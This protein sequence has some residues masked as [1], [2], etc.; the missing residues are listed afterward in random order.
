MMRP[1]KN[2]FR[3][4]NSRQDHTNTCL[5]QLA[6][7]CEALYQCVSES[8]GPS[9]A[10]KVLVEPGR[11]IVVTNC[12]HTILSR[13]RTSNPL[14]NFVLRC[15]DN[16]TTCVGDGTTAFTIILCRTLRN[17]VAHLQSNHWRTN[18]YRIQLR[19]LV[20]AFQY[21]R[22]NFEE[23]VVKPIY[24]LQLQLLP[25]H[26]PIKVSETPQ[27]DFKHG[28]TTVVDESI[29]A[30][31][32]E[33]KLIIAN[34]CVA[35]FGLDTATYLTTILEL[36]IFR[37]GMQQLDFSA[38]LP[39]NVIRNCLLQHILSAT[40]D[41]QKMAEV[42]I[43]HAPGISLSSS[44]IVSKDTL[45]LSCDF[46]Y[47]TRLLFQTVSAIQ[48][49]IFALFDGSLE[50]T[51]LDDDS[52]NNSS[53]EG[54]QEVDTTEY[55]A[56]SAD[57]TTEMPN[58][59]SDRNKYQVE[60]DSAKTYGDFLQQESR[61]TAAL[62]AFC[63]R[64]KVN[65]LF[66]K[67]NISTGIAQACARNGIALVA[68]VPPL[69]MWQL[70]QRSG[71]AT[72]ELSD[73]VAV[74]SSLRQVIGYAKSVSSELI[75]A[76]QGVRKVVLKGVK[77]SHRRQE[78]EHMSLNYIPSCSQQEVMPQLFLHGASKSLCQE[79]HRFILRTLRLVEFCACTNNRTQYSKEINRSSSY[80]NG[81]IRTFSMI[82]GAGAT[83]LFLYHH[84]HSLAQQQ[85]FCSRSNKFKANQPIPQL[86]TAFESLANALGD[87]PKALQGAICSFS[88]LRQSR[89]A[90]RILNK[91]K[92]ISR[93][94]E[95]HCGLVLELIS[96]NT[97]NIMTSTSSSE[98]E[99]RSGH[100]LIAPPQNYGIVEP[101]CVKI[102][103]LRHTLDALITY[104]R[105]DGVV[106][107]FG[108][109]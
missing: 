9:G 26:S 22:Q 75:D 36:W 51:I 72:I 40:R 103:I 64:F 104:L 71:I 99:R 5:P 43:I 88:G 60:A 81:S 91:M 33:L 83:D 106:K 105:V 20:E 49:A 109:K 78:S 21:I 27:I 68:H 59:S 46:H 77:L 17:T 90:I 97:H 2:I 14:G 56:G 96:S 25:Q 61:L 101:T 80:A 92:I 82:P 48:P 47:Q 87:I 23:F 16:F 86:H 18:V 37:S 24:S 12:G 62:L 63:A 39:L 42:L 100:F 38:S 95:K 15:V 32:T 76:R 35:S 29:I 73:L 89:D 79:Y 50:C 31:R 52:G 74:T 44:K 45:Y 11:A 7:I 65:V 58:D 69:E 66:C 85:K 34:S 84:F 19:R 53:D 4:S 10:D 1:T 108:N 94:T 54:E 8:F 28:S 98:Q 93:N 67:R 107:C 3:G 57:R 6:L 102:A 41:L 55:H 30:C 70:Q 13:I